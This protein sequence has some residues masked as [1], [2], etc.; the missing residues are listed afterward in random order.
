MKVICRNK[1]QQGSTYKNVAINVKNIMVNRNVKER[2]KLLY[3]ALS[4]TSGLNI[5]NI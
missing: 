1:V 5:L 3:V 4:R 2:N